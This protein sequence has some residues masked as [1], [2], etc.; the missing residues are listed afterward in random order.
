M[1][2]KHL[3]LNAEE[4]LRQMVQIRSALFLSFTGAME[5]QHRSDWPEF[6][7][8]FTRCELLA[9]ELKRMEQ[10]SKFRQSWAYWYLLEEGSQEEQRLVKESDPSAVG[11][12]ITKYRIPVLL[13][14]MLDKH[15]KQLGQLAAR[16]E[17]DKLATELSG[18]VISFR[19]LLNNPIVLEEI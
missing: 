9:E 14:S 8:L 6:F 7:E 2:V 17:S 3:R 12:L 11:L 15:L 16:F 5:S 18:L 1:M 19:Q 10:P 13:N 4:Y